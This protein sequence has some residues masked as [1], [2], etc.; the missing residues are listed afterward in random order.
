MGT[1][2]LYVIKKYNKFGF[3]SEVKSPLGKKSSLHIVQR[4]TGK[5]G[6]TA[7]TLKGRKVAFATKNAEAMAMRL[8]KSGHKSVRFLD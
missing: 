7:E 3:L 2:G 5:S 1:R 4:A 8:A 6:F